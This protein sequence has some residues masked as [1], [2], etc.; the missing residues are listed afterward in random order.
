M[1]MTNIE[2]ERL[3]AVTAHADALIEENQTLRIALCEAVQLADD[4]GVDLGWVDDAKIAL[5]LKSHT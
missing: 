3:R 2:A 1:A 4:C 5:G